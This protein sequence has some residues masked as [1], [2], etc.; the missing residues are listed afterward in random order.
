M[1]HKRNHKH[2]ALAV[3]MATVLALTGCGSVA[4]TE[5]VAPE[6]QTVEITESEV[7]VPETEETT[8]P[9]TETVA[10]ETNNT[11]ADLEVKTLT[12]IANEPSPKAE[13]IGYTYTDMSAIMYAKSAVNVRSLPSTDGTRL[14]TLVANQPVAVTGQCNETGWYRIQYGD[15]KAYVSNKYLVG[16]EQSVAQSTV[17]QSPQTEETPVYSGDTQM[18]M[19]T[20][21]MEQFGMNILVYGDGTILDSTTWKQI[22]TV[23]ANGQVTVGAGTSTSTLVNP[24]TSMAT[25]TDGFNRAAA[26]EVWAYMNAERVAA[27]LNEIAWDEEIYN[28]SCQRAQAL[29][30]N[31]SHNG[32]GQYAENIAKSYSD[33]GY[34]IHMLWYNSSG[35]HSN[36][37]KSGRTTG[38]CAIY[39]YN[40]IAYAVENFD[41]DATIMAKK[42]ANSPTWTA[43]NG[44]TLIIDEGG[45]VSCNKIGDDVTA[46][47]LE[48]YASH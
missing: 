48:Y 34:T 23:D 42:E 5:A 45:D 24:M 16:E 43:S 3:I 29:V 30:T 47:I 32:R 2:T 14:G 37:M 26:E 17:E 25:M 41:T 31:Y 36:Y 18:I 39:V 38:A 13:T 40:G 33:D 44:I 27:G 7:T 20:A 9:E 35:H 15:G 11:K 6:A 21:A 1:R 19:L 28:F 4:A 10:L 46:A 8:V 12:E 22:G